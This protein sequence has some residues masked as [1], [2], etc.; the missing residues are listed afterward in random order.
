[1]DIFIATRNIQNFNTLLLAEQS[2]IQKNILVELLRR[3]KKK[4]KAA[5]L[6]DGHQT[7]AHNHS[8]ENP[9]FSHPAMEA[10][11]RRASLPAV[12]GNVLW[13]KIALERWES[14]GGATRLH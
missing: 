2:D 1:M 8:N 13:R 9:N 7:L 6:A 14:E 3:E 11:A 5:I 12:F 10:S 4:L